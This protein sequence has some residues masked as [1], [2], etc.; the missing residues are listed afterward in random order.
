MNPAPNAGD[1]HLLAG[2]V[3]AQ[4]DGVADPKAREDLAYSIALAVLREWELRPRPDE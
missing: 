2:F 3:C 4:L 1:V